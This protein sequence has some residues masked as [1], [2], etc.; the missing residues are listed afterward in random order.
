MSSCE[1]TPWV[2]LPCLTTGS[3]ADGHARRFIAVPVG[4]VDRTT[5]ASGHDTSR[6]LA[7]GP[8]ESERDDGPAE[9][10]T[11]DR[12]T[13]ASGASRALTAGT[14]SPR[15][16]RDQERPERDVRLAPDPPGREQDDQ[17]DAREHAARTTTDPSRRAGAGHQPDPDEQLDVADPERARPERDRRQV[18]HRRDRRSRRA[19]ARTSCAADERV[20]A[21]QRVDA[22]RPGSPA[23]SARRAAAAGR[24][25][26]RAR[27][28][29]STNQAPKSASA[30]GSPAN[31]IGS[32]PN[33]TRRAT[34]T[35]RGPPADASAGRMLLVVLRPARREPVGDEPE[36]EPADPEG[37][38][39]D[40]QRLHR[41]ARRGRPTRSGVVSRPR[42]RPAPARR[43]SRAS[44][45]SRRA[46]RTAAALRK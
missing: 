29:A 10:G 38:R 11:P 44:R 39:Q 12:R 14:G 22:A 18:E 1:Q 35:T 19:T 37:D 2:V 17:H 3:T 28:P 27:R 6:S 33:A 20:L 26:S 13:W 42:P 40:G 43:A 24:G 15:A 23:A 36:R 21:A 41:A 5:P 8:H 9:R 30:S 32:S 34:A 25:P 4:H 45:R 46:A 16:R 7:A 31:R